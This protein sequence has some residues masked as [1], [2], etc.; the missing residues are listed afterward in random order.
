[1]SFETAVLI[2]KSW[3]WTIGARRKKP[4]EGNPSL[5][6]CRT[7]RKSYII[8]DKQ[9]LHIYTW[10]DGF[11][12]PDVQSGWG[13]C[14]GIKRSDVGSRRNLRKSVTCKHVL[15]VVPGVFWLQKE[16]F[17]EEIELTDRLHH[18]QAPETQRALW[19]RW[20]KKDFFFRLR[21]SRASSQNSGATRSP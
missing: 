4:R 13:L 3:T 16:Y 6:H 20:V 12:L 19:E 5:H 11:H 8:C 15:K 10:P 2:R 7:Q 18:P 9:W 14:R 21:Q 17:I 1:M